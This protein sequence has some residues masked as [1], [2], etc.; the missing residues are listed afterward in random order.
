MTQFYVKPPKG[1]DQGE[2]SVFGCSIVLK[3]GLV[4]VAGVV[5]EGATIVYDVKQ[6]QWAGSDDL[7][8]AQCGFIWWLKQLGTSG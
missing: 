1:I 3:Q 6:P 8:V 4:Y 7:F 2:A 5:R